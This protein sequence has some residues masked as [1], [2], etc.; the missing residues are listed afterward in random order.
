VTDQTAITLSKGGTTFTGDAINFYQA[1]TLKGAL[2]L[3]AS[4][5]MIPT[6]GFTIT[7]M[8]KLA[9]TFTGKTYKRGDA[10]KAAADMQEW[11][12]A[13]KAAM[14]IIDNR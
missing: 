4:C 13:C 5:G 9:Q 12:D 14:P 3:Y 11:V 7:K 1:A 10:A 6:R 2:K 8:L